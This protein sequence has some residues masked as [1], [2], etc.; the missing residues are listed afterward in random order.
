MTCEFRLLIDPKL[1]HFKKGV[2]YSLLKNIIK[3]RSKFRDFFEL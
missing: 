3:L 1:A 2:S